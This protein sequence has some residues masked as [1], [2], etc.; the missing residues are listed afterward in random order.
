MKHILK[1]P[2]PGEPRPQKDTSR[3]LRALEEDDGLPK[4]RISENSRLTFGKHG[5]KGSRRGKKLCE[6]PRTYL[7]WMAKDLIDTD[8]HEWAIAAQDF[9]DRVE[10]EE[11]TLQNLDDA[12][13][14]FLRQH[15]ID[16]KK[17]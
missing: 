6:C 4:V 2:S 8:F 11:A 14:E 10:S 15:N 17:L 9:L 12:A 5:P 3:V 1:F 13:D 16:P 7:R